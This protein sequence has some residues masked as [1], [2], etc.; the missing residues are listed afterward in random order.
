MKKLFTSVILFFGIILQAYS[1]DTIRS[2]DMPGV[3]NKYIISSALPFNG[4]DP[5][6][7]GQNF[8]WDFSSLRRTTQRIDTIFNPTATYPSLSFFFIDNILNSN[9]A[10]QAY[11]GDNYNIGI[12]GLT[13]IF[14]YYY[15]SNSQY[16][17]PGLG[18]VINSIPVPIFYEPHDILYKFPLSYNDK[19]S[20]S[21][22][23]HVDLTSTIGFYYHVFRKRH[24]K[25]DGWGTLTTPYGIFSVIRINSTLTESDSIF[26]TSLNQGIRLPPVTIHEFK[27]MGNGFGLPLLQ[28]NT[29]AIDS[30]V[31][32]QYQDS[33]YLTG[34]S[35]PIFIVDNLVIFPNPFSKS[36][37]IRYSL[38]EKSEIEFSLYSM[39][40]K[41]IYSS[42]DIASAGLNLKVVDLRNY[43]LA[44]GNYLFKI[45][46]GNSV[47]TRSL[48]VC[49]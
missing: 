36:L 22:E 9:R 42:V 38:T 2:Q 32:I 6:A 33:I 7:T 29:T 44:E 23:Y 18:A 37:F 49:K 26:I 24:N 35:D 41:L 14:N 40:G 16:E 13:E 48:Q 8:N 10:N 39:E 34:I 3:G 17:Q 47:L 43:V 46:A 21:Y 19:D 15:N 31:N 45:R 12:T 4:I 1:Q 11:R 5:A 20:V 28:I 27:W 25:V 30:V